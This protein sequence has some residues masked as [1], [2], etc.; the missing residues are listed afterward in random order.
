MKSLLAAGAVVARHRPRGARSLPVVPLRAAR[1][2]HL[3]GRAQA[4]AGALPDAVVTAASTCGSTGRLAVPN[5]SAARA[6]RRHGRCEAVLAD[7]V[8][9]HMVSDVPLGAFLSGGIDSS[10]VVALMA[11]ASSRPVKTFSI[12]FD[13]P[14]FD[15]LEHARRVAEHFG[16]EHHEFVVRP[17]ALVDSRSADRA[18][19]RAVRRL[20]GDSDVVRLGD[21]P[22]A[23]DGRAVGRRRRRAVRRLRPL[24]AASARGA[25]RPP[26]AAWQR[27][28]AGARLA[29]AA[30]RRARQELPAPRVARAT[31]AAI[32]I[33]SR[34]FSADEKD[35][36]LY[37]RRAARAVGAG[38]RKTRSP[39]TSR[40]SRRCRRTAA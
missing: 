18:L 29:V 4:A 35:A 19:R 6:T 32:S 22:A 21:R 10:V 39:G 25:V 12:G 40:G 33:R 36:L 30:A 5:R 37:R 17:D 14:Q 3:Q 28:M 9:S 1:P 2:R 27:Q 8:R 38:R 15:E 24:P 34:S 20:V 31:T 7:A 26:A 11:R 16:T 23:R 13:E